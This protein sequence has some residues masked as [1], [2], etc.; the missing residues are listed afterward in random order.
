M[1][2]SKLNSAIH[3]T[4]DVAIIGTGFAGLGMAMQL[5][6]AGLNDFVLLEK[7]GEVGGTWRDNH[8]PGCA[9]D[10]PSHLYSFSFA[11]NPE[12]SRLFSPQPEILKYLKRVT[13]ERGI[14]EHIRFN[15]TL[16]EARWDE[17]AGVWN[18]RTAEGD[19]YTARIL[20][21]GMGGLSRP[22][23]PQG[24]KGLEN[25]KGKT[26]H[27]QDWDHAYDL[28]GKRVAVFGTGASAIQFVPK[29]Q[30]QAARIDL[31]QRTPP[32]ITPKP[33]RPM[34]ESTQALF[35]KL[36]AV[37]NLLRKTIYTLLEARAVGFVV[38]PRMMAIDDKMA[39]AHLKKQVKDPE[40]RKKLTPDY[41]IGCKRVLIS[42]DYYPAVSK[43]NVS[44][45][46]EGI[47]EVKAHSVI[48]GNGVEREVDAI[49]FGTGFQATDPVPGKMIF[50]KGG[51]DL[52]DTWQ[53]GPEAYK[54]TTVA[55]FPNLFLIV[56]PNVGL[57]HS[58]MVYM[59][60]SQ[61][62][63]VMDALKTMKQIDKPVM[64]VKAEKQAEFN[65]RLQEKT[66]GTVWNTGG[67]K[68][69][70]LHPKSGKNVTL[71]PG[72][73]WQFR[74]ETKKFD[75]EAYELTAL[76]HTAPMGKNVIPA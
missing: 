1:A 17:A 20:I 7:A 39:R 43:P 56:G 37:Q 10:V 15:S 64:E 62:A 66:Q 73:T 67:C 30:K 59:I 60:E 25:F 23:Y 16:S 24:I 3:T 9:C 32:W 4:V 26:F 70:Y 34:S 57:G 68:S 75:T 61:V 55:G 31:Y 28:N 21:S 76:A 58:S 33:D 6:E 71:W 47:Q 14:R 36:P 48:D 65:A 22:A 51:V 52:L 41:K 29:I 8:Y 12:W 63:Y 49:I 40:L 45:V 19:R 13:D 42:N 5:K 53:D 72:F 27:S 2:V 50:G 38:N 46:T 69:W 11:Q 54:G 35:K 74:N 18:I 44:L